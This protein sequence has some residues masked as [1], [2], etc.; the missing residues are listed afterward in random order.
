MGFDKK[1][2]E[3][4]IGLITNNINILQNIYEEILY[5]P[6]GVGLK[7]GAACQ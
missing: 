1:F 5:L 4:L 2:L 7:P 6:A 3:N